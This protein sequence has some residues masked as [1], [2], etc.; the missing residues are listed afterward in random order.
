MMVMLKFNKNFQMKT[1]ALQEA[2]GRIEA[3]EAK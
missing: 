3:L 1:T 2:I